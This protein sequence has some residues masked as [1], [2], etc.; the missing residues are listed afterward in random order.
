MQYLI[1]FTKI[2]TIFLN[3]SNNL[4]GACPRAIILVKKNVKENNN[5]MSYFNKLKATLKDE[6]VKYFKAIDWNTLEDELDKQTW[7]KL[8]SQFWLDT[9]VPV[10]N[11][12]PDWR[13]LSPSEKDVYN[14]AFVGLTLLDTLQSEEGA[15]VMLRD[16]RTQHEK[17]VL[18]NIHFMESVSSVAFLYIRNNV[19]AK[20]A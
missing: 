2:V 10:S 3:A 1:I 12:L 9:R 7:E 8:T 17:A 4:H 14:K 20:L 5:K 16:A 11:D 15:V 13:E 6:L 18:S 19:L